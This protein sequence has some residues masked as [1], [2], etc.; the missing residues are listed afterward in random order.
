MHCIVLCLTLGLVLQVVSDKLTVPTTGP[1]AVIR[2]P[3]SRYV[4]PIHCRAY[5]YLNPRVLR[6]VP[7]YSLRQLTLSCG[8][9]GSPLPHSFLPAC[10]LPL[11]SLVRYVPTPTST[12]PSIPDSHERLL[13]KDL[14]RRP[15]HWRAIHGVQGE[16][17]VPLDPLHLVITQKNHTWNDGL[18]NGTLKEQISRQM[19]TQ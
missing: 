13:G 19:Y 18:D 6:A 2:H 14:R 4:P 10:I 7:F 12:F 17:Q 16:S 15:T 11:R 9:T 8:G 3:V 5:S 1:Y